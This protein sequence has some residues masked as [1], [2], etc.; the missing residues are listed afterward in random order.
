MSEDKLGPKPEPEIETPE[1]HPGGPDAV[2]DDAAY[3]EGD[4][5][6]GR[7]LVPEKNPEVEEHV[8]DEITVPDDKQQEPHGA[9]SGDPEAA[10]DEPSA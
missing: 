1:L 4:D 9:D 10:D 6:I 3:P 5:V 8:P 7:D 2:V